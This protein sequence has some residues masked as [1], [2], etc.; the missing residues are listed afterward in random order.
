MDNSQP[1]LDFLHV[2]NN[3]AARIGAEITKRMQ[4]YERLLHALCREIVVEEKRKL[5]HTKTYYL[6][7]FK[8]GRC[9][10]L[11]RSWRIPFYLPRY[12]LGV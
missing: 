8:K 12:F 9:T 2:K 5:R 7:K 6:G 3:L 11:A 1:F 4:I 10:E